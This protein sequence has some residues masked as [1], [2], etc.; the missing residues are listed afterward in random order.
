MDL[1]IV[2]PLTRPII[3]GDQTISE[4][5]FDEADLGAQ[6]AYAELAETIP[7]PVPTEVDGVPVM[8]YPPAIAAKVNRFWIA[9]LSDQPEAVINKLKQADLEAVNEV[10]EKVMGMSDVDG[11]SGGDASGN[12][13][14]AK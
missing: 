7:D 8:A 13:S 11:G 6:I 12:V 5:S 14:A 2:V 1:P 9:R 3:L 10:V 4:L